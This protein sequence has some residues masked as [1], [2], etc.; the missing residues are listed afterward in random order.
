[1]T[2]LIGTNPNQVPTNGMLGKAAFLDVLTKETVG[3]DSV[4]NTSDANKPV[5]TAQQTA[6]NLKQDTSAKDA[7]G[8]YAG[9][10]LFKLNLKNALNTVTSWFTTAATAARTWTMPDKDGTVAMISDITGG[11]EAGSFTTVTAATFLKSGDVSNYLAMQSTASGANSHIS[12]SWP[13]G[14]GQLDINPNP[15]DGTGN[16]FTRVFRGVTTSGIV[17]FHVCLGDGTV[18]ANHVLSGKGATSYLSSINGNLDL[19]NS[20]SSV[21]VKGQLVSELGVNFTGTG[22]RITGDFSNATA[23]NRLSFVTSTT[24]GNTVIQ[25]IPNGAGSASQLCLYSSSDTTNSAR[26]TVNSSTEALFIADKVGTGT[27]IPMK[28]N[29][30]GAERLRIDTNGAATFFSDFGIVSYGDIKLG[31]AGLTTDVTLTLGTPSSGTGAVTIKRT[32]AGSLNSAMA[33]GTTY[34]G[35]PT[36]RVWISGLGYVGINVSSPEYHF[37]L[38]GISQIR[39]GNDGGGSRYRYTAASVNSRTWRLGNDITSYGDFKIQVSTTQTGLTFADV[40][41]F[42]GAGRTVLATGDGGLGYGVGAGGTVVQ[43]TDK[44]TTVTINKPVGTITM[45][46][47]AL[48]SGATVMFGV[49][50]TKVAAIDTILIN[51]RGMASLDTYNLRLE[52]VYPGGFVVALKNISGGSLSEAIAVNFAVIKGALS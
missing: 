30:G 28:F 35:A 51:M 13:T 46:N 1:M 7:S 50:N 33:L 4:D 20:A 5:S 32:G 10:T 23:A 52:N 19:G 34:G 44:S 14:S 2:N 37:D 16:S 8:G 11:T 43:A 18:S 38:L 42:D 17:Q 21:T 45:S 39:S 49:N 36:D 25:A 6:L 29:T 47:A 31:A 27:Y 41:T 48:P 26:L 22:K 3:L 12:S 9:L 24:N 15:R 40:L